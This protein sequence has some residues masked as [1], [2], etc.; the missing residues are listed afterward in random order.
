[1]I[2]DD[3]IPIVLCHTA[4]LDIEFIHG[5]MSLIIKSSFKSRFNR[6]A[7]ERGHR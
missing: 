4:I 2:M 7:Y 6:P 1:M 5:S 3:R